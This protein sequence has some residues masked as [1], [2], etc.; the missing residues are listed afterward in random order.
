MSIFTLPKMIFSNTGWQELAGMPPRLINFLA[1]VVLPLTLLPPVMLYY[2]GSNYGD[3]FVAGFGAKPWGA[4]ATVFF[5]T[6]IISVLL[7]GWLI[8]EMA[9]WY[10]LRASIGDAFMLAGIAPIPMWLSSLCLLIP[11]I[12]V[13]VGIALLALAAGCSLL[14]RGICAFCHTREEVSA[15][16]ITQTVMSAGMFCWALLLVL[17]VT[18]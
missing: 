3:Q 14:Y 6:E 13:D 4:I 18:L 15:A 9:K 1:L 2:A 11:N 8:W 10:K 7:M 16:G 5:L 12:A 17:T